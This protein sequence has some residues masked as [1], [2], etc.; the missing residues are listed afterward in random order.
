[1]LSRG[2][3]GGIELHDLTFFCSQCSSPTFVLGEETSL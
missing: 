2:P 1:M 3:A